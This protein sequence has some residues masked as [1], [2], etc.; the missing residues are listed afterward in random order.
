MA[1]TVSIRSSSAAVTRQPAPGCPSSPFATSTRSP[2]RRRLSHSKTSA[3]GTAAATSAWWNSAGS[4]SPLLSASAAANWAARAATAD[5]HR[6]PQPPAPET[7]LGP[8][9]RRCSCPLRRRPRAR[10]RASPAIRRRRRT[11]LHRRRAWP[12]SPGAA[13]R[14]PWCGPWCPIYNKGH[15]RNQPMRSRLANCDRHV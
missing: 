13:R 9:G 15:A 11:P 6:A 2:E 1:R 3:A 5:G 8:A 14:R 12:S 7:R 10:A 4:R